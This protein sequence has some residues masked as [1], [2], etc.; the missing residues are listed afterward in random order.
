MNNVNSKSPY[1]EPASLQVAMATLL[2]LI[3]GLFATW[4]TMEICDQYGWD[5][6]PFVL[7]CWCVALFASAAWLNHAL[8]GLTVVMVPF[9][10]AVV[11]ILAI[12]LWQRH[13][14]TML[15]PSTG[16]TYGYFLKPDGAKARF[17]VLDFPLRVG[18]AS[19]SV[20][21]IA[22]VILGWR[23]G[24]R[25][26]LACLI[27][28]WLAAALIFYLPSMYLDGQGNASIFI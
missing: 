21:F 27:P 23:R 18:W 1:K 16:L 9:L 24:F 19:L 2:P 4:A 7:A 13:A 12:W 28:W 22:A 6:A 15:I 14:F 8:F 20:C 11:A 26:S 5:K 3:L 10:A 17:W 25:W